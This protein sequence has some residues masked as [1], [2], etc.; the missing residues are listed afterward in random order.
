MGLVCLVLLIKARFDRLEA[1]AALLK[2][3]G[4]DRSEK[5]EWL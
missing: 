4:R 1:R 5:G 3:A 2:K